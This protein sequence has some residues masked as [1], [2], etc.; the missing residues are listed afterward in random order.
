MEKKMSKHE[1][2]E[3]NEKM[4]KQNP[5]KSEV[6]RMVNQA[7]ERKEKKGKK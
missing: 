2:K 5:S 3:K 4:Y 7:A 6:K 1:M